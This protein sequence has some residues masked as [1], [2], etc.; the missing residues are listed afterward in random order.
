[1]GAQGLP[2]LTDDLLRQASAA[3][4][5]DVQTRRVAGISS[6][7]PAVAQSKGKANQQANENRFRGLQLRINPVQPD[8]KSINAVIYTPDSRPTV[9]ISGTEPRWQRLLVS[10][11]R[12]VGKLQ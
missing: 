4:H 2:A 10:N 1:M 9:G 5:V 12:V 7:G 6:S 8:L 11:N 3:L